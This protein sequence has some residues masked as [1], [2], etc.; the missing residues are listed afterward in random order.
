MQ[1]TIE[2]NAVAYTSAQENFW[3]ETKSLRIRENY[4]QM[5]SLLRKFICR[6]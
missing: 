1:D 2:Q 6:D 4:L 3:K 5:C